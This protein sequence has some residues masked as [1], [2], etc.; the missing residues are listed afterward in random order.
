MQLL[1]VDIILQKY[2]ESPITFN[3]TYKFDKN[4]NIYDTSAK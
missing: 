1:K 3:P 4:T 2:K